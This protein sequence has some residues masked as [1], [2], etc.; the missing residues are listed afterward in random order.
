M[1]DFLSRVQE[2]EQNAATLLEKAIARNQGTTRKYKNELTEERQK[3]EQA[4]QEEMKTCVQADRIKRRQ[5]YES[6]MQAGEEE[7]QKLKI[8]RETLIK[9]ALPEA[10]NLLL[11]LL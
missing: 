2:A 3:K 6:Q 8:E 4:A 11:N 7:A 1:T 5:D 9:P 10:T